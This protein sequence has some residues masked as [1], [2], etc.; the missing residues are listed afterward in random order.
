[1]NSSSSLRDDPKLKAQIVRQL[2]TAEGHLT[3]IR[4]MVEEEQYCVDILKQIA[5]VQ[6]IISR[7]ARILAHAHTLHCV[8]NAIQQGR[9]EAAID[10]LFEALK[11]LKH[12]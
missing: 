3:G 7:A 12:F 2:R 6:G 8:R 4:K 5:A 10:E 1:M 11:Y 9:G